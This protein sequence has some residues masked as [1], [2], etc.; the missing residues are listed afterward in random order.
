MVLNCRYKENQ[1][2]LVIFFALTYILNYEKQNFY[3][4]YFF[5]FTFVWV[6]LIPPNSNTNITNKNSLSGIGGNISGSGG[7]GGGNTY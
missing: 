5:W 7:E 1:L 2:Y 4:V 6:R 3:P